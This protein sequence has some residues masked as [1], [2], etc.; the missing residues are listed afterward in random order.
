MQAGAAARKFTIG[1]TSF[2]LATSAIASGE[3]AATQKALGLPSSLATVVDANTTNLPQYIL[4]QDIHRHPEVQDHI[5]AILLRGHSKWGLRSVFLEGAFSDIDPVP[6]A[7]A[8][9]N[10][11]SLTERIRRGDL[12][13]AEMAVAMA[14]HPGLQ[15]KGLE[16]VD[17]Y[18][19]NLAAWES[20]EKQ[21]DGALRELETIRLLQ[22]TLDVDIAQ[23]SAEQLDH[24]DLLLRLKMKPSEYA[25]YLAARSD[26]GSSVTL[27]RAIE[28][29]ETF[30]R[31]ANERSRIFLQRAQADASDG[32]KVLVIGGFHTAA[33]AS[34]LR[35]QGKTF[36][37]LSP[38]VTESGYDALYERRLHQSI[39]A[40]KINSN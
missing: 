13:G 30:Y 32:P 2:W 17:L 8:A 21:R 26:I 37:V 14:P 27:A 33:M 29:A 39:S 18:K 28:T 20:M 6:L 40:L 16:A 11:A 31:L 35:A 19:A 5:A 24:L 23:I 38:R 15:L 10:R 4:I 36:A 25:D 3:F 12:S 9:G 7:S 1:W 22:T 34:A